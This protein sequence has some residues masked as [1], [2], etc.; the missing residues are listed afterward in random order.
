MT[1]SSSTAS[2]R[3]VDQ[4]VMHAFQLAGLMGMEQSTTAPG[5]AGKSAFGRVALDSIVDHLT[6]Y[7][8]YA[9]SVGFYNQSLAAGTTVYTMPA[10]TVDV[11]GNASYIGAD[12]TDTAAYDGELLVEQINRDEWQGLSSKAAEGRPLKF[13]VDRGQTDYTVDV[14][15]WPIPE[16]A[17]TVRFQL[18]R[19]P[20]DTFDGDATLDLREYWM[21]YIYHKLAAHLATSSSLPVER[22]SYLNKRAQECLDYA[23]GFANEHVP[24]QMVVDHQTGWSR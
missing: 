8:V 1:V 22:C 4:V 7:G 10:T 6:T 21:E 5:W 17:G 16:E 11:V 15:L 24:G 13:F 9:R 23:R 18:Q 19:S 3:T 20:A 12:A 2:R 14:R